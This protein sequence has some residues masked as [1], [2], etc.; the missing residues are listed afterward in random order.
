MTPNRYKIKSTLFLIA[1]FWCSMTAISCTND[2]GDN[3]IDLITP[4]EEEEAISSEGNL[5]EDQ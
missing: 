1:I 3:D 4:T 2:E 5:D